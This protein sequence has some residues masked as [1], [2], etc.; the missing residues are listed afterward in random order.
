V[1]R[2]LNIDDRQYYGYGEQVYLYTSDPQVRVRKL[3]ELKDGS[4]VYKMTIKNGSGLSRLEVESDITKEEYEAVANVVGIKPIRKMV[5]YYLDR[6]ANKTLE[7]MEVNDGLFVYLEV[8]FENEEEACKYGL[9]ETIRDFFEEC[10]STLS[11]TDV[12]EK[13]KAEGRTCK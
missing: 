8:E 1:I 11:M 13:L 4:E 2:A 10:T 12:W 6:A 9:P 5:W 7:L 3:I